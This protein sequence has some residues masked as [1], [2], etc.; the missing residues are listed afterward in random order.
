MI[1]AFGQ[2]AD[3]LRA[4]EHDA[5]LL[6][7]AKASLDISA[8]SLALL[9]ASYKVGKS[10]LLQLLTAERAY[11]QAKQSMA[12]AKAQQLTDAV[13]FFVSLGVTQ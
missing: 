5:E 6:A 7:D 11:A 4:L 10:N 8:S 3:S 2:V 13:Q 12:T 1:A 9:Q